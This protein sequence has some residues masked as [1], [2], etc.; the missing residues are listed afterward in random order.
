MIDSDQDRE[1][2]GGA[3]SYGPAVKIMQERRESGVI[4]MSSGAVMES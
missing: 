1:E 4:I 2:A 3:S